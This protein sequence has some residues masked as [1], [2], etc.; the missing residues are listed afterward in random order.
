MDSLHRIRD[1][2]RL[3]AGAHQADRNAAPIMEVKPL[4]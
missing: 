4:G 2:I 3:S 1:T